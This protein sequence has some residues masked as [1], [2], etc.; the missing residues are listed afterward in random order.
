MVICHSKRTYIFP[1]K[2]QSIR[3]EPQDIGLAFDVITTKLP[4]VS[5]CCE[6]NIFKELTLGFFALEQTNIDTWLYVTVTGHM[7]ADC[8]SHHLTNL[9]NR[10]KYPGKHRNSKQVWEFC[11]GKYYI[12][13]SMKAFSLLSKEISIRGY[14]SL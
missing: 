3:G 10:L 6:R 2:N 5:R 13:Y 4:C 14:M 7:T 9:R 8:T 12:S 1:K 11:N